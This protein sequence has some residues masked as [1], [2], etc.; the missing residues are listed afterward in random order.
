MPAI[1]LMNPAINAVMPSPSNPG[2]TIAHQHQR[3]HFVVAV[4][5]PIP[6]L[7]RVLTNQL[8]QASIR[9]LQKHQSKQAGQNHDERNGHLEEGP[10]DRSHPRRA[11]IMRRKDAL[12][13]QEVRGPIAKA[14]H[15]AQAEHDSGPVD[16]HRVV[17][18]VAHAA[19]H[20]ACSRCR[21]SCA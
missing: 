3:Q 16:A 4:Q 20:D 18:E 13:N 2:A 9:I 11:Q 5:F 15:E 17:S 21:C 1:P 14:D 7:A 8:H 19:P 6:A 12:H 10:D